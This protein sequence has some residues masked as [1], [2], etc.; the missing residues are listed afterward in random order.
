MFEGTYLKTNSVREI[1]STENTTEEWIRAAAYSKEE[2]V[3]SWNKPTGYRI[4]KHTPMCLTKGDNGH[5]INTA[6]TTHP[7]EAFDVIYPVP[8]SNSKGIQRT[9]MATA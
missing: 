9:P 1:L 6:H 8:F 3:V 4:G 2:I 5:S 7:T